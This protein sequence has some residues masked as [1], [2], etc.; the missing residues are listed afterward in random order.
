VPTFNEIENVGP[1]IDRVANA[2]SAVDFELIVV[3]DST[4]GTEQV[5]ADLARDEPR[6]RVA[7]RADRRGLAVA[8]TDGIQL[9]TGAVV[10]V[11]DADLQHPAEALPTLTEALD[12]TGADLAIGSRYVPGGGYE[13][14]LARKIVSRVATVMAKILVGR[15]RAIADPLSGFFAFRRNIVEGVRLKPIGF[16]ILL[17]VLARGR[18]GRV[19]E[20]PYS[21]AARGAGASKLTVAQNLQ[22]LR[23]LLVLSR[24]RSSPIQRV[25]YSRAAGP[26]DE[27]IPCHS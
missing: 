11:L 23:H 22:Y 17:E 12:H 8:V 21:F 25:V 19:V 6:L 14:S 18:I 7:H 2:L 24:V 9:A 20:V 15:A 4:D 16:K 1:L 10:C 3:D 5:L 27:D 26:S 13:F